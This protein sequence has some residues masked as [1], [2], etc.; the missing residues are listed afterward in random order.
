[1]KNRIL[2]LVSFAALVIGVL[3]I[4]PSTQAATNPGIDAAFNSKATNLRVNLNALLH[5]HT[6][7]GGVTLTALYEGND[8]TRLEQLMDAN[9]MKI[10]AL[11]QSVY[12]SD[13]KNKFVKLWT[14]HMTE[15]KNYTLAKKDN[16]TTK[17]NSAKTNLQKISKDLGT[18]L[19]SKNLKASTITS[20]MNDHVNGT[21]AIVDAVA[22]GNATDKSNLLKKGF[23]QAG[24]FA[25]TLA[26][27]IILD[28]SS[29]FK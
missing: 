16:D 24:K 28:H 29:M 12:G 22:A 5:E 27:G 25:D 20:L 17:M 7:L 6:V 19:A 8:T 14:Q 18:T 9:E 3:A 15:Y 11:V 13:K 1:M 23:D 4:T 26:R 2:V 21:L 10:A